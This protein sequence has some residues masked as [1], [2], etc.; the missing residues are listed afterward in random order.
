MPTDYSSFYDLAFNDGSAD[1]TDQAFLAAKNNNT[2]ETLLLSYMQA[3]PARLKKFLESQ[4]ELIA[5]NEFVVSN[6]TRNSYLK[7]FP[8][9]DNNGELLALAETHLLFTVSSINKSKLRDINSLNTR[10]FIDGMLLPP[11][12][13]LTSLANYVRT[14]AFG[15]IRIFIPLRLLPVDSN[16][17]VTVEVR[18]IFN[19][20]VAYQYEYTVDFPDDNNGNDVYFDEV[21]FNIDPSTTIGETFGCASNVIAFVKQLNDTD[22][23]CL[24]RLIY[25]E[26]GS[27]TNSNT[28]EYEIV[29]GIDGSLTFMSINEKKFYKEETILISNKLQFTYIQRYAVDYTDLYE[30]VTDEKQCLAYPLITSSG[31][32]FPV[33]N[34]NE[35]DV[36]IAGYKLIPDVDYKLSVDANGKYPILILE[37]P[38]PQNSHILICNRPYS[39]S[40][41]LDYLVPSIADPEISSIS[42]TEGFVQ[43]PSNLPIDF[44]Y[45]DVYA[46]RKKVPESQLSIVGDNILRITNLLH[47][48]KIEVRTRFAPTQTLADF[49]DGS[50]SLVQ[51]II[52]IIGYSTFI[53]TY[54]SRNSITTANNA[55]DAGLSTD[56][57]FTY[58]ALEGIYM[59]AVRKST[60]DVL[61][62]F[63]STTPL[64]SVV[65]GRIDLNF[66]VYGIFRK[67]AGEGSTH[68]VDAEITDF[69]SFTSLANSITTSVNTHVTI[70]EGTPVTILELDELTLGSNVITATLAT[71]DGIPF[72]D[73]GTYVVT[74]KPIVRMNI[75]MTKTNYV[76]GETPLVS[77]TSTIYAYYDD[78]SRRDLYYQPAV[79]SNDDIT[80]VHTNSLGIEDSTSVGPHLVTATWTNSPDGV[81]YTAY[82]DYYITPLKSLASISITINPD[83]NVPRYSTIALSSLTLNYTDSTTESESLTATS[84]SGMM[85]VQNPKIKSITYLTSALGAATYTLVYTYTDGKDYTTTA[86]YVVV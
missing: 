36:F 35:L 68:V 57:L 61:G 59:V 75:S 64:I 83:T 45:L 52:D 23:R 38:P 53:A 82:T 33:D 32:I 84:E 67:D 65:E 20:T 55:I 70:I 43:L 4:S 54:K 85:V 9:Y 11:V 46:N 81:V 49:V 86:N 2:L 56:D 60:G 19:D 31:R 25:D 74:P 76:F 37:G 44:S 72:T 71:N 12:D 15:T 62:S 58:C 24:E 6:A 1:L 77:P 22:Y 28:A 78:M 63:K 79:L 8:T 39:L 47:N 42:D 51:E 30:F 66:K 18:N 41:T 16:K 34:V 50:K 17:I 13:T 5:S 80:I 14:S 10:V 69:C 40:M 7:N 73:T 21:S 29:E 3:D 26:N 27:P 48:N